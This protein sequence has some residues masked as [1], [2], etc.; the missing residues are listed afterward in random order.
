[1][2]YI[3][4]RFDY[5]DTPV[6]IYLQNGFFS[7]E[8]PS[9]NFH[10]H[11]YAEC[12]YIISG[13]Y[14]FNV[15]GNVFTVGENTAVIINPGVFHSFHKVIPEG[16]RIVFQMNFP[17]LCNSPNDGDY[18]VKQK[19]FAL[20]DKLEDEISLF[21]Q[22]HRCSMLAE[23]LRLFFSDV[24]V[25]ENNIT[26]DFRHDRM[27]Q[28]YEIISNYHNTDLKL[29]NISEELHL[30]PRQTSRVILEYFGMN[31][32]DMLT[33]TRLADAK[34]QIEHTDAVL[35]DIALSA[36]FQ[37]YNGFWKAFRKKYGVKPNQLR[38]MN[39]KKGKSTKAEE[40]A[41]TV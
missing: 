19:E 32:S 29:E 21:N 35:T 14:E 7:F 12:H 31:F 28:I 8:V 33:E 27:L 36:G 34:Y 37:S 25:G 38:A 15:N 30:S 16:K 41:G 39:E 18:S 3:K 2:F 40:T 5:Y 13:K 9:V 10:R 23:Y 4:I 24:I 6:D 20:T 1:M 22:N 17:G 11:V 26:L